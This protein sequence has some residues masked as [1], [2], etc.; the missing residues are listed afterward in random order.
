MSYY[1]IIKI[2][3]HEDC[4]NVKYIFYKPKIKR[5]YFLNGIYIVIINM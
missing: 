3:N 2:Q 4:R 5:Q 1:M